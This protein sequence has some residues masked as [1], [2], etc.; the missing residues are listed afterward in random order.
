[1]YYVHAH[2]VYSGMTVVVRTAGNPLRLAGPAR[3]IMRELDST[4]AVAE[5]RTMEAVLGETYA[6]ERFSAFLLGGF[7]M[8]ALLLAAIGIYGV[9]AYSVS[10]RTREIGVRMAIGADAGRIV[11]MVLGQGARFV[12]AGLVVG[13]AGALGISTLISS[14]LFKTGAQDPVAFLAGPGVLLAVALVAGYVP[15]RRASRMDPMRALRVE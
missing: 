15:A 2:L 9:L 3:R 12:L 8:A 6:R 1:V 11:G 14:L 4:I 13:L 10:E 5:V 7:S